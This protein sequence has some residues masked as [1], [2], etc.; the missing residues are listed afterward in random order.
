[1]CVH[2]AS[3]SNVKLLP[4]VPVRELATQGSQ[5]LLFINFLFLSYPTGSLIRVTRDT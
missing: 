5:F 3:R 1:M 2:A 4:Y